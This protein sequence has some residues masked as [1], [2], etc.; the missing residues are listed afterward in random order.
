ME[1]VV[2]VFLCRD[3]RDI[4]IS[5]NEYA[6]IQRHFSGE[7]KVTRYKRTVAVNGS[8]ITKFVSEPSQLDGMHIREIIISTGMS[9]SGDLE[10]LKHMV[11]AARQGRIAMKYAHSNA[12]D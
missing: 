4:G 2:N 9:T 3:G 12:D 8:W 6:D 7:V 1:D 5:M 11:A 10:K